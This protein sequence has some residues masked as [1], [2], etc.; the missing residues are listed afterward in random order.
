MSAEENITI[1][2]RFIAEQDRRK[3]PPPD[4]ICAPGYTAHVLSLPPMDL[5]G[6]AQLAKVFYAA[7]P[8]LKQTIVDAFADEEKAA[9]R[10]TLT[11][12]HQ[13]ELMDLAPTGKQIA[14]AGMMTFR[15]VGGKVEESSCIIDEMALMQQIGAM[16]SS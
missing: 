5:A 3:G 2:R 15:I 12:T 6:H 10:Y 7:F 14:V 8:D 11:G 13:G 9:V 1:A 16:P 4:E